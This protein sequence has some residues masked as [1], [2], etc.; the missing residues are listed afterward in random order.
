MPVVGTFS[1]YMSLRCPASYGAM[2][3][4]ETWFS[5]TRGPGFSALDM[6]ERV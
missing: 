2:G 4:G 3:A 6:A 1:H 5:E